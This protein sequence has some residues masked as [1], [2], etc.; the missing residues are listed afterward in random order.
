[1]SAE[2]ITTEDLKMFKLEMIEEIKK[3]LRKLGNHP[4]KR[5]LRS[6]E[7]LKLLNISK[8]TLQTLRDNGSLPY[9]KIGDIIYYDMDDIQKMILRINSVV[10]V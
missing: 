4:F 10:I 1:M 2:I 9:S 7:V 5:W 6:N 8:G 3:L